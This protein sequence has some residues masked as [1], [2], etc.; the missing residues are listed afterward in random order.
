MVAP[1]YTVSSST[2]EKVVLGMKSRWV[3]W[4]FSKPKVLKPET[5]A[6]LTVWP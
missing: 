5:E 3:G 4:T 1:S 6:P 2:Q